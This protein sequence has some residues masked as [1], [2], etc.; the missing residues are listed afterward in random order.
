MTASN[1][2]ISHLLQQKKSA[3]DEDMSVSDSD[4]D[5]VSPSS[6]GNGTNDETQAE[7]SRVPNTEAIIPPQN[8]QVAVLNR[9][10]KALEVRYFRTRLLLEKTTEKVCKFGFFIL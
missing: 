5:S 1:V 9:E 10:I 3:N 7:P 6:K 8:S 2:L 4:S